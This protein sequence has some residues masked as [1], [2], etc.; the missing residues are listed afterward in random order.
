MTNAHSIRIV[1][2]LIP[3]GLLTGCEEPVEKSSIRPDIATRVGSSE[4][5]IQRK[6]TGQAKPSQEINLAF[7]VEGPLVALHVDVGDVANKG[8]LVVKIDP[9]DYEVNLRNVQGSLQRS[10]E[11]LGSGLTFQHNPFPE[12]SDASVSV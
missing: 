5:F 9:R 7:R 11:K 1:L 2:L 3:A 10:S 12:C 4:E 8:G 6:F